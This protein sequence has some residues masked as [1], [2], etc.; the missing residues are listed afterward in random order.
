MV[1]KKVWG[2]FVWG[3]ESWAEIW[4][5]MRRMDKVAKYVGLSDSQVQASRV[6]HGINVLTP[7]KKESLWIKFFGKF[8]D[9]LIIIL[10]VALGLSLL[11]ALYDCFYLG[12]GGS[13][14]FE[15]MGI[16]AAVMLATLCGFIFETRA[17]KA[18]DLLNQVSDDELV[19]VVRG[20]VRQHVARKDVVVG[21]IVFLSTGNEVP[22]DG[23][24][25]EAVSMGVDESS[26]TGE[27]ICHKT[28]KEEEFDAEAT[29][30]SNRVLRG[31]KVLEGHGVMKVMAVGDATENGKVFEAAR[32]D[33]HVKTPLDEQ[34]AA[35]AHVISRVSYILA[36]L[37]LVGRFVS[38]FGVHPGDVWAATSAP[39]LLTYLLQ[40]LMLAVTLVVVSVP[41]GLPMA[42]TLSLAYSMHRMFQ[43]KFLV[44]K[45]HACETMGATTVICT[46]KTGTLTQNQMRVQATEFGALGE[47]QKLSTDEASRLIA[48]GIAVNS[49]ASLNFQKAGAAEVLGNPTEGALL[50]WLD[51]QGCDYTTL[52]EKCERIA[53]VP[54]STER[55]YMASVVESAA[56]EGKRILYVKGAPE[57][58]MGLCK[59]AGEEREGLLPR[60]AGYQA[61]ALRTLGFAYRVLGEGEEI[62]LGEAGVT[63]RDLTFL[64]F[65]AIADP[66]RGDV[67]AAIRSCLK[68]GISVKVVTGDTPN[69]AKEI[70]RQIGLWVDGDTDEAMITGPEFAALS[71]EELD[72]RVGKLKVIA[73][74]RPMDKKR[75]V[76]ALRRAG[77]VVAVTGDGTNDAPAL[78]AAHVGLSMGDGT[79]VAKEASDVTILDNSFASIV[80]AIMWGRSLYR[81]IQRFILFQMTVNVVACLT[82]LIGA[83]FGT[84]SPLTVTQMLWVNLIM[85][86]FAAMAMASLPPNPKVMEEAP[87]KRSAFIIS[88]RMLRDLVGVGILFTALLM[89]ALIYLRGD[90]VWTLHEA[91]VFFTL[92]VFLQFWNLIRVRTLGGG[93]RTW[94]GCGVFSLIG[95]VIL[96][97]QVVLVSFGGRLFGVAALSCVEWVVLFFGTA[98]VL[99]VVSLV[100]G[101]VKIL[102]TF[103]R[104]NML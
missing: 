25:L 38:F 96:V 21:D 17:G 18:F 29:F 8:R 90:H 40:S 13:A 52:R 39:H 3:V 48:E 41:E 63:A 74:S 98:A 37:V 76:E 101:I 103:F 10:L 68:A 65:V 62:P 81:N 64:G 78:K 95:L 46:D 1:W 104:S 53:E 19:E 92:F 33:D 70:A 93:P 87:R 85:D 34:L 36:G 14:F 80:R 16:F 24:L 73:R 86:T 99:V 32:I 60:L 77:A 54:F 28:T 30:P 43:A 49:T 56:F 20:G 66:V 26:L 58:V 27:A 15:P 84:S 42:V 51:G 83:F 22:A 57:I 61:R 55:K 9:P 31:T 79:S 23:D 71:E 89:G 67:P 4:Y 6:A 35:L 44:R 5:N 59:G 12:E 91:S 75:L 97:G 88:P 72:K 50:L 7:P 100:S 69:T 11:I 102:S 2:N 45:L 47:G 82:V 94:K